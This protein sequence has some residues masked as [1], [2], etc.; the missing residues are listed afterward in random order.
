MLGK[1]EVSRRHF[2]ISNPQQRPSADRCSGMLEPNTA[3]CTP[4][5]SN[6]SMSCEQTL[7]GSAAGSSLNIYQYIF[8]GTDSH[9]INTLFSFFEIYIP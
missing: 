4:Y 5:A 3:P 6:F 8:E 7:W 2:E 9:E 1:K